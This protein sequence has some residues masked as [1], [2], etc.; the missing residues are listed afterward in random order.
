MVPVAAVPPVGL[1]QGEQFGERHSGPD[2]DHGAD[3]LPVGR[4]VGQGYF[5]AVLGDG[6][7]KHQ[8]SAVAVV[9]DDAVLRV[10]DLGEIGDAGHQGGGVLPIEQPLGPGRL[11]AD[12][13]ALGRDVPAVG[14]V[15]DHCE[16]AVD[17]VVDLERLVRERGRIRLAGLVLTD[18]EELGQRERDDLSG[19]VVGDQTAAA[20]GHL[21]PRAL[22]LGRPGVRVDGQR[23]FGVSFAG[24]V[25]GV[26]GSRQLLRRQ[27]FVKSRGRLAH[28]FSV[29][30]GRSP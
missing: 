8:V 30:P 4:G 13:R 20:H 24:D 2:G 9:D 28:V 12:E 11:G 25:S 10:E 3:A 1:G 18:V 29:P 14:V 16:A 27:Q 6:G 21:V 23:Q 19:G 26:E 7:E 15:E 17:L 5:L 22:V